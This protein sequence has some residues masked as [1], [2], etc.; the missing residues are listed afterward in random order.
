MNNNGFYWRILSPPILAVFLLGA[1]AIGAVY[2]HLQNGLAIHVNGQTALFQQLYDTRLA[3]QRLAMLHRWEALSRTP[4]PQKFPLETQTGKEDFQTWY[5]DASGTLLFPEQRSLPAQSESIRLLVYE[6]L[7]REFPVHGLI[8]GARGRLSI[9]VAGVRRKA[10]QVVGGILLTANIEPVLI[11]TGKAFQE[12][13]LVGINRDGGMDADVDIP[14]P[15]DR[16]FH[17]PQILSFNSAAAGTLI[18]S[19][20]RVAGWGSDAEHI[21]WSGRNHH[22]RRLS[23]RDNL[24]QQIGEIILFVD[25]TT[26]FGQARRQAW[27]VAA[28]GLL[29]SVVLMLILTN[30]SR[31]TR[32]QLVVSQQA[33]EKLNE[34]LEWRF[35]ERTE[36]LRRSEENY[37]ELVES[38]NSIILRW[39][40]EGKIIFFNQYA[41][42]FFGFTEQEVVGR[43]LMDCIVPETE[44]GSGRDLSDLIQDIALHPDFYISNINENVCKDG[45]RV[46]VS[47]ANRAVRNKQGKV[48]EILSIGNDVSDKKLFDERIYH[49]AHYDALTSL[50][51]RVLFYE[52]LDKALE[53]AG[54]KNQQLVVLYLDLDRFKPVND[55]LGHAMGDLLLQQVGERLRRCLREEDT[56]ARMSGDEFTVLLEGV[57]SRAEVLNLGSQVAEKIIDKLSQPFDLEGY[58]VYVSASVGVAAYPQDGTDP[59]QLMSNVDI[60]MYHAKGEGR[61][62]VAFYE[63]HM[64]AE[65]DRRLRL[66]RDLRKALEQDELTL[67]YQP[68]IDLANRSVEVVEALLRWHH[69][70]SGKIPPA[71]FVSLAEET[72]LVIPLGAWALKTALR[73]AKQW[74]SPEGSGPQ[75]A[76]N[77]SLGQFRHRDL[78]QMVRAE[79][80][81]CDFPA[82]RLVLEITESTVMDGHGESSGQLAELS[83]M[84]IEIAIDDFGTGHSS[85]SRLREMPVNS[86]KIDRSFVQ[87]LGRDRND[88]SIVETIIAMGHSLQLIVIAEGVETFKQLSFLQQRGCHM[89]QGYLLYRPMP[90]PELLEVLRE[91]EGVARRFKQEEDRQIEEPVP[92]NV[93]YLEKKESGE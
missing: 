61:G 26:L 24:A 35:L 8:A 54:R 5:F 63:P 25:V 60:A 85:L 33:L 23:L 10:G 48:V 59:V 41:Q 44:S 21:V 4:V 52:R 55:S 28:S 64:N 78:V 79:L 1:A 57:A 50:P 80:Q 53:N 70:D 6:A 92:D 66:E 18:P 19:L 13:L 56:V 47:W 81:A 84:G 77:L 73:Q 51:N 65:V 29:I 36:E 9:G 71:E 27:I 91:E 30:Q 83:A 2:F 3:E 75:L 69:P 40:T 58:E 34:K 39:N 14:N 15:D 93:A 68:C 32:T 37:R 17:V 43:H 67:Y 38:A 12:T 62:R 46:W 82:D 20:E 49:L 87:D 90:G 11:N 42:G 7:A 74:L 31:R 76:V 86:L 16:F 22:L 72:G 45:R 89:V 88:E